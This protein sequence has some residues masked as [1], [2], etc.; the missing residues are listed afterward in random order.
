MY[1]LPA[2]SG[3]GPTSPINWDY[4]ALPVGDYL[5]RIEAYRKD[6]SL[7]APNLLGSNYAFHEIRVTVS[8]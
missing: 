5:F 3:S 6:T 7:P 4:S 2:T 8:N 1:T